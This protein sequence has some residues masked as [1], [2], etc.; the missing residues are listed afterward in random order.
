MSKLKKITKKFK[1]FYFHKKILLM[2][3]FLIVFKNFVN[4]LMILV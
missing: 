2:I 1:D 4:L 3:K